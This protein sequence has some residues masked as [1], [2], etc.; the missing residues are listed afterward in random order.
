MTLNVYNSSL[1][2]NNADES[3]HPLQDEG[4]Q[5]SETLDNPYTENY[6]SGS[7]S[8]V[9]GNASETFA[10][11]E[12]GAGTYSTIFNGGSAVYTA[13]EAGKTYTDCVIE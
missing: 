6:G 12:I 2:L 7:G 4:G 5:I 8:F 11:A 1:T 10:G 9:I 3:Q 13:L